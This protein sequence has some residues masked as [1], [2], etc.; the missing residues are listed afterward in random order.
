[1]NHE[2]QL[3]AE[4]NPVQHE[5]HYHLSPPR[6]KKSRAQAIADLAPLIAAVASVTSAITPL[7]VKLM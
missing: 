1:M 5:E 7:I 4:P 3:P 2:D 6:P